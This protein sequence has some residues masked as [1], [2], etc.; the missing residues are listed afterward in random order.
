MNIIKN[1]LAKISKKVNK[2]LILSLFFHSKIANLYFK[3]AS[4][5]PS[6]L[7]QQSYKMYQHI[8]FAFCICF[9]IRV[10]DH[11]ILPEITFRIVILS[12][13]YDS[14]TCF[15][16][17]K[18]LCVLLQFYLSKLYQVERNF[19]L[20]IFYTDVFCCCCFNIS[21]NQIFIPKH[22]QSQSRLQ[23]FAF[24]R[25]TRSHVEGLLKT[26]QKTK[27][28]EKHQYNNTSTQKYMLKE[29]PALNTNK[30]LCEV[31]VNIALLY[32]EQYFREV[33]SN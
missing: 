1:K 17:I 24:Y 20:D 3:H 21:Q 9:Y 10:E 27:T 8:Q 26:R 7:F 15:S 13:Q 16:K 12:I 31:T 4:H 6:S 29:P 22:I 11:T 32:T 18:S 30:Y 5:N 28:N 14:S 19:I 23:N 25:H 33:F 2:L